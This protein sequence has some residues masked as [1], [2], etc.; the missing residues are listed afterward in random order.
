MNL[1]QTIKFI[2]KGNLYFKNQAHE[3]NSLYIRLLT[4]V[5]HSLKSNQYKQ[6][7]A[8][9]AYNSNNLNKET[10]P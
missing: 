5:R 7:I 2:S 9:I 4:H 8:L 10:L 1:I 6:R 3:V